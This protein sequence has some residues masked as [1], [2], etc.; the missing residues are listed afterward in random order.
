MTNTSKD[1]RPL[2][3]I[4]MSSGTF[5]SYDGTKI[6]YEV[7]GKGEPIVFV[8]GI[9]C[10]TNHWRYQID[11]FAKNYQVISFDLRGHHQS[12]IPKDPLQLTLRAIGKDLSYL[13]RTLG[14]K[15]AHFVGH[16]FGVPA[17]LA[18]YQDSP[19]IFKSLA[20]INGFSKNPIKGMFGLDVVEPFF[21]FVKAQFEQNP[22]LWNSLWK[23]AVDNPLSMWLSTL[24]GGFNFRVTQFKDIEIY[25]KGVSQIPLEVFLPLF[26]D[27]MRFQ[28]DSIAESI[29]RPTLV[30]SGEQDMV[31]PQ[32]FQ[33]DLHSRIAHSSLI[34]IPYGSHCCQLDFPDYVNLKLEEFLE[35]ATE[36]SSI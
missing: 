18:A 14:L 11:H 12:S 6:Y 33:R 29:S 7:R 26:E 21:H 1:F 20:F 3:L 5:D 9:A 27:M 34:T 25:A 24:A 13:L 31:T 16:S 36:A 22:L 17:M 10:L 35:T 8:Y 2:G 15:Q 32:K 30:M 4:G 23:A 28:G 19:A